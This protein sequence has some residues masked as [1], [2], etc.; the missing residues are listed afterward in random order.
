M[1]GRLKNIVYDLK[2]GMFGGGMDLTLYYKD[3]TR[4]Y[5]KNEF[6]KI[7]RRLL[8]KK[9]VRK[10]LIGNTYYVTIK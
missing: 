3:N 7:P 2:H 5:Y 1:K 8:N 10:N 4:H 6:N 9:V